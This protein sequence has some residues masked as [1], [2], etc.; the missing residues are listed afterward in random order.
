[1]VYFFTH[2]N[3]DENVS[4]PKKGDFRTKMTTRTSFVAKKWSFPPKSDDE[5]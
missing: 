2:R 4:S 3:D 1:M 5:K